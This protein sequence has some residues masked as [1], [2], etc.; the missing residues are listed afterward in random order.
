MKRPRDTAF[1]WQPY[2]DPVFGVP[3]MTK[4]EFDEMARILP[5]RDARTD[6][7]VAFIMQG[8]PT[9]VPRST[10]TDIDE[11]RRLFA[12][13][14]TL[15]TEDITMSMAEYTP[16]MKHE[17][18]AFDV[19][20]CRMIV[21]MGHNGN[22]IS[23]HFQRENRM[24]CGGYNRASPAAAWARTDARVLRGVIACMWRLQ[25]KNGIV[26]DDYFSATRLSG[27]TYTAAQFKVRAAMAVYR[28]FDAQNVID[29]S[30][31]WGDR[32]AGWHL[33]NAD[34]GGHYWGCDPNA[35]LHA[36]YAAQAEEYARLSAGTFAVRHRACAAEDDAWEDVPDGGADLVFTSPP[37]WDTERYAAGTAF[38]AAQ[39]WARYADVDA[40]MR[41]FLAA[42]LRRVLPKLRAGGVLAVN[43]IDPDKLKK[44]DR[45][46]DM[47]HAFCMGE[48]LVYE[49]YIGMRMK[50]RPKRWSRIEKD[51]YMSSVMV[52]PIWVFRKAME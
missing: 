4:A 13:T 22:A 33:A 42:T 21:Q 43:I 29:F 45:V 47:L 12:Y 15:A 41:G 1:D 14:R 20:A 38:E 28:H 19:G 48:G 17:D 10:A 46:C 32:L 6:S 11:L 50:N 37:Y 16:R 26:L 30:M 31:G 8:A 23:D 36:G 9:G 35:D 40:W 27:T 39:S 51:E 7:L 44:R 34:R 25:A 2:A 52:E 24:R 49:G 5:D 3:V 18:Y